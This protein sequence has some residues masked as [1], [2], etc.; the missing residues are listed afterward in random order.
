MSTTPTID[1]TSSSFIL[2]S[3]KTRAYVFT[4]GLFKKELLPPPTNLGEPRKVII[5]CLLPNCTRSYIRNWDDTSTGSFN[6]HLK[7]KHPLVPR[8][9]EEEQARSSTLESLEGK[10]KLIYLIYILCYLYL[11]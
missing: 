5:T 6:K 9:K 3:S 8:S 11:V 7:E 1:P 2:P 4:S 10:L